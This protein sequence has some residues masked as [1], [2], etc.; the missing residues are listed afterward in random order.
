MAI[1]R[2]NTFEAKSGHS[3]E[4]RDFLASII[5]RISGAPGCRSVELLVTH[6]DPAR[7]AIIETWDSVDAH[8]AAASRIPSDMM[9]KAMS[10][11]ASRPAGAY[12]DSLVKTPTAG[13]E[14]ERSVAICRRRAQLWSTTLAARSGIAAAQDEARARA[15]E[16][17]Y[18]AD[19]IESGVDEE[20]GLTVH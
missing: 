10:L 19:L 4:L 2:I 14:R 15:N 16:A 20:S 17:T 11:F 5:D 3:T 18:L 8:Q 12:Y 13:S 6:D 9:Q 1:T 7:L